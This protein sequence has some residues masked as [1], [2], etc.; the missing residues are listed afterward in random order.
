[1]KYAINAPAV[2]DAE[3]SYSAGTTAGR[4]IFTAGQLGLDVHDP[5]T[6]VEGGTRAELE[7]ALQLTSLL[8]EECDCTLND[9]AT[10]TVLLTSLDDLPVVDECFSRHFAMPAPARSVAE[11]S[12][13]PKGAHVELSCVACR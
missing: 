12:R 9:I 8:L 10:V 6:L 1:M 3:G 5:G 7:R 11:V 4:L 2:P 13:L